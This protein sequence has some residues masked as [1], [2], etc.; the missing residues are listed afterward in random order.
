MTCFCGHN[1]SWEE[2]IELLENKM[3]LCAKMIQKLEKKRSLQPTPPKRNGNLPQL[4]YGTIND[5]PYCNSLMLASDMSVV[6]EGT[7]QER[8][9]THE[10]HEGTALPTPPTHHSDL[11]DD[12]VDD[13][14]AVI[15]LA[16]TDQIIA[17]SGS[18][19]EDFEIVSVASM[20][21]LEVKL[22][23]ESD[24]NWEELSEISSVISFN[25]ELPFSMSFLE[26]AKS[27]S[28]EWQKGVVS[29]P[30]QPLAHFKKQVKGR[31]ARKHPETIIEEEDEIAFL[32]LEEREMQLDPIHDQTFHYRGMKCARGGKSKYRFGHQPKLKYS[33]SA[34]CKKSNCRLR[35]KSQTAP[36]MKTSQH[37]I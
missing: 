6:T 12:D 14:D 4:E 3:S 36:S 17:T 37:R 26:A 15:I 2:A 24:S 25:S 31:P 19:A 5:I 20:P 11:N 30:A 29:E 33:R 7:L 27:T 9:Q 13:D 10:Q 22:E 1:F 34:Q 23:T 28:S 21:G 16:R 8:L 32:Q 35:E 18:V